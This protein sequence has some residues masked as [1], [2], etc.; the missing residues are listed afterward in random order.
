MTTTV[1]NERWNEMKSSD[2]FKMFFEMAHGGMNTQ[3][4]LAEKIPSS[5]MALDADGKPFKVREL[6][7]VSTVEGTNLIQTE[8][9]GTV[10]EGAE[11]ARCVRGMIPIMNVKSNAVSI[12]ISETGTYAPEIAEGA[13]ALDKEIDYSSRTINIKT[14][15]QAIRITDQMVDDA[16]VDVIAI[17][18]AKAGKRMENTLNQ[19]VINNILLYSGWAQDLAGSNL[20]LKG[21][22]L[23]MT[24][25]R[26]TYNFEPNALIMHPALAGLL[27]ADQTNIGSY[28][29]AQTGV[30]KSGMMTGVLGLQLGTYGGTYGGGTY[31]YGFTA[32]NY[33]GGLLLNKEAGAT[34]AMRQDIT[35][36][37]YRDVL[38]GL[39]GA[40]VRMR[41]GTSYLTANAIGR[42]QY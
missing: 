22:I 41:F 39:R 21:I 3:R 33:I 7:Q 20:N 31:T 23:A 35:V 14:Y 32:D 34:I 16:L 17:E 30:M 27:Y 25:M 19:Q 2:R 38:R 12:P 8:V 42:I 26:G 40:V 10:I 15:G 9:L 29:D 5:V 37:D 6:L 18:L 4:K 36:E 11:P 24:T 28:W 13:T 1:I